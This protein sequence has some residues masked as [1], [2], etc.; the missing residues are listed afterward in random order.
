[1]DALPIAGAAH[2]TVVGRFASQLD[3]GSDRT[4]ESN[5][6]DDFTAT[7]TLD[8]GRVIRTTVASSRTIDYF[9]VG[10]F[11]TR[12]TPFTRDALRVAPT[13]SENYVTWE[14]VEGIRRN[15]FCARNA[16]YGS[17]DGLNHFSERNIWAS[18]DGDRIADPLAFLMLARVM[19]TAFEIGDRAFVWND[20]LGRFEGLTFWGPATIADVVIG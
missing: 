13:E 14:Y 1:M 9:H 4:Q 3:Y 17:S 18:I 12:A 6:P 20:G 8:I 10:P 19:G 7:F 5:L 15:W 2:V 11:V 16:S